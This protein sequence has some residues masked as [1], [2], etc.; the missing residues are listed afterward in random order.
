MKIKLNKKLKIWIFFLLVMGLAGSVLFFP[1]N[2]N[3]RYTCLFHRIFQSQNDHVAFMTRPLEK[4]MI[5]VDKSN[6]NSKSSEVE[7]NGKNEFSGRDSR[8][9]QSAMTS[10]LDKGYICANALLKNYIHGYALFWWGSLLLLAGCYF[11]MRYRRT[12]QDSE[13]DQL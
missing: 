8:R 5:E 11:L 3:S 9:S 6:G 2:I 7:I 13:S 10:D 12:I 4:R 1:I